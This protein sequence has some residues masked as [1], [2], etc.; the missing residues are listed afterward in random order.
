MD[1][2][3]LLNDEEPTAVAGGNQASMNQWSRSVEVTTGYTCS[4]FR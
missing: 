3:Q 2:K 4:S 1:T